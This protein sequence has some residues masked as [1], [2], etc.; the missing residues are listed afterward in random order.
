MREKDADGFA[1]QSLARLY[2]KAT[3]AGLCITK[4][5]QDEI[6]CWYKYTEEI[7]SQ[8]SS[9]TDPTARSR[10]ANLCKKS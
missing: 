2:Q 4:A 6:L 9:V 8:D 3:H 1:S 7:R 5:N 10:E